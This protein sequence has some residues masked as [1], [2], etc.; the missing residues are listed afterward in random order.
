MT[1]LPPEAAGDRQE[2]DMTDEQVEKTAAI[3]GA[4]TVEAFRLWAAKRALN[5]LTNRTW[6]WSETALVAVGVRIAGAWLE[7]GRRSAA[8]VADRLIKVGV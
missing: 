3:I 6:D 2:T 5:R 4:V 7:Q 1:L 8:E